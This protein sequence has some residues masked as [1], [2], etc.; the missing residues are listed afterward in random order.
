MQLKVKMV[1]SHSEPFVSFFEQELTLFIPR[2]ATEAFLERV[3]AH[4]FFAHRKSDEL[5]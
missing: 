2:A 3:Q 4:R 1:D 5:R